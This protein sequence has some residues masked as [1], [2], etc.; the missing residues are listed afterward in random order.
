MG[1]LPIPRGLDA[2]FA[3]KLGA[4]QDLDGVG[5]WHGQV[6]SSARVSNGPSASMWSKW[7]VGWR[8]RSGGTSPPAS[9]LDE[10]RGKVVHTSCIERINGTLR[11]RLA[12]LT[13]RCRH[14]SHS[15]E[16]LEARDVACP[17][18]PTTSVGPITSPR[19]QRKQNLTA[20]QA[21]GLTDHPWSV[22]ELLAHRIAPP[23]WQPAI[24][25]EG[26][27]RNL[28]VLLRLLRSS[29]RPA[30]SA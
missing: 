25:G 22:R 11:E 9:R 6:C 30:C 20:A 24:R 13:R 15:V 23:A 21:S 1:G 16:M 27:L 10:K 4:S 8:H 5:F 7:F 29:S 28:V 14:A 2:C 12:S 17:A 19:R 3:K 26:S 18:V